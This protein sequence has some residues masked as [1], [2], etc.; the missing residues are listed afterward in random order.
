MPVYVF[1]TSV[2][3][4]NFDEVGQMLNEVLPDSKW[5]FDFED[6]DNILR[7]ESTVDIS[8]LVIQKLNESQFF[9]EELE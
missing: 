4:E 5:N 2:L 3:K 7:V 6:V 1:K 8:S 9:C